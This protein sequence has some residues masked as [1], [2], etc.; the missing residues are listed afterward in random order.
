ML[1]QQWSLLKIG[2]VLPEEDKRICSKCDRCVI[3][4]HECLFSLGGFWI[5]FNDFKVDMFN[6]FIISPFIT[7]SR[8]LTS[9]SS[10]ISVNITRMCRPL[11]YSFI[12]L[13]P[14]A[15][16]LIQLEVKV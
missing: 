10:N 9:M 2:G 8:E 5:P 3:L 1:S 16:L 4:N 15:T 14:N 6:H 12:S 13:K 7:A 11:Q